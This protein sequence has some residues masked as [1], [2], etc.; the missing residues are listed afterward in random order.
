MNNHFLNL[1]IILIL[2]LFSI[3]ILLSRSFDIY[4]RFA[5]AEQQKTVSASNSNQSNRILGAIA[6]NLFGSDSDSVVAGHHPPQIYSKSGSKSDAQSKGLFDN[7]PRFALAEQQKTVSASNSNQSNRI[8]GAIA[9]N[10]WADNPD[11]VVAGH[12]RPIYNETESKQDVPAKEKGF[13]AASIK[14]VNV[15]YPSDWIKSRGI[16]MQFTGLHSSPIVTFLIPDI[17]ATTSKSN[18]VGIA[19]YII[20]GNRTAA[21]SL[22]NYVI[23]ELRELESDGSFHL[24]ESNPDRIGQNR[25]MA[26][27]LVYATNIIDSS[28]VGGAEVIGHRKTMEVIT[29]DNGTAYFF[30][31]SA[32]ADRYP[33]YLANALKMLDSLAIK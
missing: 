24:Y 17:E 21:M 18:F 12:H 29:L 31:Y 15:S 11:A 16:N 19:K 10:L 27:R 20:G 5:L 25:T 8:L 9:S 33:V 26:Q 7:D 22:S 28:P 32:N 6:S 3:T 14:P 13:L 4:P 1:S 2:I 23:E 30:V